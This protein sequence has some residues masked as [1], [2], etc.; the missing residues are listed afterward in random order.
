MT[1]SIDTTAHPGQAPTGGPVAPSRIHPR[2]H[3]GPKATGSV[4]VQYD[5]LERQHAT[6]RLGMWVF[7]ASESL[8]FA[9][10]FAL[11]AAYRFVYP[12]QFHA[13]SAHA[14]LVI[15]TVNTY[16]LLTSSLTMALA[17]HAT[18][19]SHRRRTVALLTA[20]I[21]LGLT[22]DVLKGIEYAGHLA[23]GLAPGGYYAF[24]ALPARG[25]VLYVTL[26]Y[27]LTGLHALHVTGGLCVLG[28]LA[29]RAQRG[30]FT[31]RS[32]IAL[33][34]GGLYW[35]LVDLVW[36]FLWPLLYLIR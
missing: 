12:V 19:R 5:S 6:A 14:N 32:H 1:T 10:L 2:S 7:L 18:R 33:E 26:Y 34:L 15:G 25:V 23:E 28:W 13:A 21:A 4:Q 30:D 20:T 8:L 24:G 27:L 3:R 29:V 11:Y 16:L 17:I 36:I 31:P 22:F 9:G 35:H